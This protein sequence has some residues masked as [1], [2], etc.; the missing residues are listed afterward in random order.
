MHFSK[1]FNAMLSN[2][3]EN[4][5]VQTRTFYFTDANYAKFAKEVAK[6]NRKILKADPNAPVVSYECTKEIARFDEVYENAPAFMGEFFI[7]VNAVR[8]H[9]AFLRYYVGTDTVILGV[10]DHKEDLI[11]G[12][13]DL[14]EHFRYRTECDH[15]HRKIHRNKTLIIET[16]KEGSDLPV[17]MQIGGSCVKEYTGI[18]LGILASVLDISSGSGLNEREWSEKQAYHLWIDVIEC[19]ARTVICIDRHGFVSKKAGSGSATAFMVEDSFYSSKHSEDLSPDERAYSKAHE[20]LNALK[21][22]EADTMFDRNVKAIACREDGVVSTRQLPYIVAAVGMNYRNEGGMHSSAK[23]V[24]EYAGNVGEVI[25]IECTV[26]N[27][28]PIRGAFGMQTVYEMADS[29]GRKI[30]W[31]TSRDGYSI[32]ARIAFRN[33]TV[34]KHSMFKGMKNTVI[35]G[36]SL[37]AEI[38]G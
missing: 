24:N 36:R 27:S 38:V 9:D 34:K 35:G 21:E 4:D 26:K 2:S 7:E 20:I 31:F 1:E 12:D 19:I 29:E 14:L 13:S 30:S 23:Y 5:F 6:I 25:D 37:K 10:I 22:K 28:K 17:V 11:Y 16:R 32:G 3:I 15:C 18:D 8:F 33:A